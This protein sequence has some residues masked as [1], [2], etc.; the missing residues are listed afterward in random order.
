MVNVVKKKSAAASNTQSKKRKSTELVDSKGKGKSSGID[1]F[2]ALFSEK[3]KHDRQI[4]E[5]E[6]KKE[7]ARKAAKKARYKNDGASSSSSKKNYTTD[8]SGAE[9]VDDGLGGKYNKEGYTGRVE[10]GVKIFKRHILNK[11][12]AGNTKDCPFDCNCCFI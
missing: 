3:K 4:K 5:D 2:D 6:A 12:G 11:P 7:A 1:E 8:M 10:D 9:W